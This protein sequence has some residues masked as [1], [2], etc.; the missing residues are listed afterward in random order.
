[1]QAR[2]AEAIDRVSKLILWLFIAF[3][4]MI[5]ATLLFDPGLIDAQYQ[6]GPLTPTRLF[7]WFSVASWHL[8]MVAVTGASLAMS[9][10]R[11]RRWLHLA[12]AGFYLWD[13]L[14]QWFYW[15]AEVG[16]EAKTLAINVGVSAAVAALMFVVWWRERRP[17]QPSSRATA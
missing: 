3:N 10:A 12:N 16:V 14:T 17:S 11:E 5:S 15:G 1:M 8:F 4:L 13:A 7:Q 9:R 6:G 2:S